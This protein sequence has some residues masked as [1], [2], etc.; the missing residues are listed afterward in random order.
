MSKRIKQLIIIACF[1]L[2]VVVVLSIP[3]GGKIVSSAQAVV[4]VPEPSTMIV[5]GISGLY[6]AFRKRKR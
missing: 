5:L 3:I 1:A 2:V 6:F 4:D